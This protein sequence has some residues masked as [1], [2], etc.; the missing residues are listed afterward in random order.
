MHLAEMIC[1]KSDFIFD[2][3]NKRL[4][5]SKCP[6]CLTDRSYIRYSQIFVP[7]MSC[8]HLGKK[9]SLKGKKRD[10]SFKEKVSSA[11]LRNKRKV[12]PNYIPMSKECKKIAHNIRSRIWQIVKT[13]RYS[14]NHLTG[15]SWED[16]KAHLEYKFQPGMS[17]DNYGRDGWHIDHIRPLSSFDLTDIEQLK[18]ACHYSNLQP[19]WA[20]DNLQ[21]SDKYE[22]K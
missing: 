17:W 3:S 11:N 1:D 8:G 4:Y 21:K 20:K 9:S 12:N 10:E 15:L 19:L 5:R 16:L 7:C 18:Q 22:S 6:I 14:S 13:K 2:K